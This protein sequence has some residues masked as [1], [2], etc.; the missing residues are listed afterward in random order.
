[1]ATAAATN[2]LYRIRTIL[3]VGLLTLGIL[4]PSGPPSI[5]SN[6]LGELWASQLDIP[7]TTATMGD[8]T[9]DGVPELVVATPERLYIYTWDAKTLRYTEH[10]NVGD[11]PAPIAAL[12]AADATGA[13]SEDLW[14][15]MQGSGSIQLYSLQGPALVSRGTVG[16]L[17]S[18]VERLIPVDI[19]QDGKIDLLALGE[20]G[21]AV[22]LY[23]EGNAFRQIWRTP[24]GESADRYITVGNFMDNGLP[25]VITAKEQGRISIYQWEPPDPSS[26]SRSMGGLVKRYENYPWGVIAALDLIPSGDGEKED[27]FIATSQN[28]LY[29]YAWGNGSSR[30][31][32]Q[33]QQHLVNTVDHLQALYVPGLEQQQWLG[34][35]DGLLKGWTLSSGGFQSTWKVPGVTAWFIQTGTGHLITFSEDRLLRVI[36]SVSTLRVERDGTGYELQFEPLIEDGELLLAA[37]DLSRILPLTS[38]TTRSGTRFSGV[39]S[40]FQFFVVDAGS[41][42]ASINGRSKQLL[43]APRMVDDEMYLPLAFAELLGFDY[44]WVE[45]LSSLVFQ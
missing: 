38:W 15:G 11:F 7:A 18:S 24:A 4:L 30:H 39:A 32:G 41:D 8:L 26:S 19:D 27:L 34:L 17:W 35:D 9:G 29:R 43:P 6:H 12:A 5:A 45:A 40:F 22:L 21:L 37:K 42:I 44:E 23:N 20:D 25:A 13:G 16:R 2:T 1:M 31:V 28:L 10:I 14:V 36:G 3:I 33:W